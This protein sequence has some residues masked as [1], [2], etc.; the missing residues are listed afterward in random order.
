MVPV[1]PRVAVTLD[2]E[3]HTELSELADALG[4]TMS[5]L[6]GTIIVTRLP[7]VRLLLTEGGRLSYA[8]LVSRLRA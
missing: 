2:A 4:L 7:A 8:E 5:A 1:R 3:V 6:A